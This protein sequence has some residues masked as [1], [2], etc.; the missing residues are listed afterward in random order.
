M[1]LA[2]HFD[3]TPFVISS[4]CTISS[5]QATEQSTSIH[6]DRT[7]TA[8]LGEESNIYRSS[9]FYT[10]SSGWKKLVTGRSADG[11]N[12]NNQIQP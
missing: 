4:D 11:K 10:Q 5:N 3:K 9:C 8:I 6:I 2:E 1:F 12:H 7:R